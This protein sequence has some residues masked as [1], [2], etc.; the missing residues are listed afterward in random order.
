MP[1]RLS[2]ARR[3][4]KLLAGAG[5]IVARR[6]HEEGEGIVLAEI[7]PGLVRGHRPSTPNT[8]WI[9]KLPDAELAAWTEQGEHGRSYYQR[10]TRNE[11]P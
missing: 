8:F 11:T 5:E 6:T 1:G 3:R 4:N 7:V 9:P 2:Q 10:V